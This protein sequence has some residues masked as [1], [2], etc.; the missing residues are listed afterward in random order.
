M[1]ITQQTPNELPKLRLLWFNKRKDLTLQGCT[2]VATRTMANGW[3]VVFMVTHSPEL[4]DVQ[5]GLGV[6][7]VT[8]GIRDLGSKYPGVNLC[9]LGWSFRMP[10][11][12]LAS[13]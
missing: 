9:V 11:F 3:Y 12:P 5:L 1:K 2:T 10:Q 13:V 7:G 8:V 4:S 6:W